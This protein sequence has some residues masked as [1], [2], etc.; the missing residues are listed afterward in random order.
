M[1]AVLQ[2]LHRARVQ[3]AAVRSAAAAASLYEPFYYSVTIIILA[4]RQ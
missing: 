4:I 3:L 1:W 2:P